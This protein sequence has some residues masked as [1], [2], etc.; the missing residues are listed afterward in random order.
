M[1]RIFTGAACAGLLW[2][3]TPSSYAGV[4]KDGYVMCASK[5]ALDDSVTLISQGKSGM[6]RGIGCYPTKSALDGAVLDRGFMTSKVL[7]KFP[8]GE[9]ATVYVPSEALSR[10]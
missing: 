8:S 5:E 6:L 1:N 9:T 2:L 4:L 10:K 3:A 7:L